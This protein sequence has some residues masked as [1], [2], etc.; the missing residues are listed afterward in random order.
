MDRAAWRAVVH[1]VTEE[2]DMTVIKQ[3]WEINHYTGVSS[4]IVSDV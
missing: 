3:Q 4:V 1:G 2:S